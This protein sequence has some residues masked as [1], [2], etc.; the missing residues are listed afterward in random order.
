MFLSQRAW[1]HSANIRRTGTVHPNKRQVAR[2]S[3]SIIVGTRSVTADTFEARKKFRIFLQ[4]N[5]PL[6][7]RLFFYVSQKSRR[8]RA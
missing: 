5:L 1:M 6:V 3:V 8:R 7:Q 2:L 4:N